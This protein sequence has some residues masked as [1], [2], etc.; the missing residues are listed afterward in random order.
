M[1]ER[2]R[3]ECILKEYPGDMDPLLIRNMCVCFCKYCGEYVLLLPKPI[4][5]FPIRK[6]DMSRVV[7]EDET[8]FKYSLN[9]GGDTYIRRDDGLERQC[10]LYCNHCKLLIAYRQTPP[11]EPS[12]FFYI[13]KGST[14][15]DPDI[16]VH[17]MRKYKLRIPSFIRRDPDDPSKSTIIYLDVKYN[18]DSNCITGFDDKRLFVSMKSAYE[19]EGKANKLLIHFFSSLMDISYLNLSL[20]LEDD[21]FALRVEGMDY[22]EVYLRIK[23]FVP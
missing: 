5:A 11:G 6:R 10:R 18:Q 12:P 20:G 14:T 13:V 21:G 9:Y 7:K 15:I 8:D 3:M 2:K 4:E 1:N 23:D 16:M 19:D 22:E 17:E